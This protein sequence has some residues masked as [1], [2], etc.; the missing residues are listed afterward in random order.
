MGYGTIHALDDQVHLRANGSNGALDLWAPVLDR[1]RSRLE[2][3][4]APLLLALCLAEAQVL[5]I[6]DTLLEV[7]DVVREV[8][9]LVVGND[10]GRVLGRSEDLQGVEALVDC[11][12]MLLTAHL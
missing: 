10:G 7:A 3:G 8:N 4:D 11:E 1:R 9:A 12:V 2:H 5:Q 6:E